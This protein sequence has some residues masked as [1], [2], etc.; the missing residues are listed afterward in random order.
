M[1][2]WLLPLVAGLAA[3]GVG[4]LRWVDPTTWH[5]ADLD[6][7]RTGGRAVSDGVGLYGNTSGSL[8][9]TY[10]PFA[11]LVFVPLAELD[12][13]PAQW[14]VTTLSLAAYAVIAW[15]SV[16]R[17]G[18]ASKQ[19]LV[20]WTTVVFVLGAALEPVQRTFI[21]GQVNLVLA[22]LVLV[23]LFVLP[24]RFKGVLI[25]LVAGIKL[26]P[27]FFAVYYLVR[28]DWASVARCAASGAATVAVGWVALPRESL[29]YWRHDV[30][31]MAK[32]DDYQ[33]L[34]TNQSVRACLVRMLGGDDPGAAYLVIA[35]AVAAVAAVACQRQLSAGDRLAAATCLGV[36]ALLVSPISWTHHWV[37]VVPVLCVMARRGWRMAV[38]LVV[39]AMFLPPMWAASSDPL[40]L[41]PGQQV[42][43]SSYVL[44]GVAWLVTMVFR[45]PTPPARPVAGPS[46]GAASRPENE[47]LRA[48]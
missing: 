48:G 30:T 4:W 20:A 33:V 35:V 2:W 24:R 31:S 17:A 8:A 25:G 6:V 7:F 23:D 37:W 26:T 18:A 10:P 43:A 44:L 36:G 45:V 19:A 3:V 32:F 12:A 16:S 9:F 5:F 41:S 38:V 13:V 29:R 15:I 1:P 34:P 14:V 22:A 42:L 28:R 21:F 39:A 47:F 40:H 27:A 11:A 46:S